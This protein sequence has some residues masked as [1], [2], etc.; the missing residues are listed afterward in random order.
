[1]VS[2]VAVV[3]A[4]AIGGVLAQAVAEAGHDVTLCVR[5]PVSALTVERAGAV[6]TVPARI[7]ADPDTAGES[8]P[9]DWVLLTTKAHQVNGA[10]PWL[11][12]L[13]GPRTVVVAVQNGVDHVG[14][15]VPLGL[16][17]PVL[18]AIA[19]ISARRDAPGRVVHIFG[20]RVLVP[21]GSAGSEF[22]RLLAGGPVTVELA[23]DF[24][25]EAWRKLLVNVA[26]NPVTALTGRPVGV[27]AEPGIPWLVRGLLTEAVAAANAAGARLSAADVAATLDFYAGLGAA[28][29]TSMLEDRLAGRPTEHDEITGAVV[30][31]ADKHGV[32]VPLNRAVLALLGAV[33]PGSRK[34]LRAG[35]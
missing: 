1:M 9:A 18:P 35:P 34:G 23:A 16:R 11:T 15:L 32:E 14:R 20:D 29:G 10:A 2:K 17:G 8:G 19:Y 26:A 6:H 27:L 22:A 13:C 12:G 3:G 21:H 24:R 5:G 4:G 33:S 25:T 7:A 28:M 31:A 30:R